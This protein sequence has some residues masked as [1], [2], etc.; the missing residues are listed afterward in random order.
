M[1]QGGRGQLGPA[2]T[3][4]CF[5]VEVG[6][7]FDGLWCRPQAFSD[8]RIEGSPEELAKYDSTRSE[9]NGTYLKGL[10]ERGTIHK[11]RATG[12]IP[13]VIVILECTRDP[14]DGPA[15]TKVE[16]KWTLPSAEGLGAEEVS[17]DSRQD[18]RGHSEA[19]Q[20][21]THHEGWRNQR[22]RIRP[23]SR[24]LSS[25]SLFTVHYLNM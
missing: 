2:N 17:G 21:R 11:Y 7:S 16:E 15:T 1:Y 19:S 25:S 13:P 23:N 6:L 22:Q 10:G 12:R 14:D 24:A 20:L 9:L 3:F 5:T 18:G 4:S 8:R